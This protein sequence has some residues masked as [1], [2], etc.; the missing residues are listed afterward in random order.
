MSKDAN[1][2][3]H[4]VQAIRAAAR[5]QI[6]LRPREHDER[7]KTPMYPDVQAVEAKRRAYAAR[8]RPDLGRKEPPDDQ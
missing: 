4:I 5:G 8:K 1:E 3:A 6:A 2:Q 7:V